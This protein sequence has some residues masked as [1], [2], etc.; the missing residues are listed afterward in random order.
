MMR[1]PMAQQST[2]ISN[3]PDTLHPGLFGIRLRL[4]VALCGFFIAS[5]LVGDLT[6]GKY[7]LLF[8][9]PISVGMLPFPL[10][11]ILTD[12][13]HEFYGPRGARIIT[14]L[15]AGMAL[16]VF[17]MLQVMIALPSAEQTFI[18]QP[19]FAGA[20]GMSTRLLGAS[21]TA[22]IIGQFLD[23]KVFHWL[24]A[25]TG[26]KHV[27]LRANGSTV[28]S[29][30]VDT[31]VINFAFLFGSLP[32]DAIFGIVFR[33]YLW[34]VAAAIALT[35]LLYVLHGVIERALAREASES[36]RATTEEL[37]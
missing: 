7:F 17:L 24:K 21:L 34:K 13:I 2:T 28:V 26:S 5:W 4:Y 33:S 1:R 14:L 36:P 8:G 9:E 3:D 10:T 12:V 29:Q 15:A 22:F 18:P 19:I 35:P 25:R 23:V 37:A 32:N 6:G 30:L 16:Y 11:F 20:F 31:F 27:W